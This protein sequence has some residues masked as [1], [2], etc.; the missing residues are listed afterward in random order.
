VSSVFLAFLLPFL[1][2]GIW[3]SPMLRG[4]PAPWARWLPGYGGI[5]VVLDGALTPGF[6]EAGSV[7]LALGWIAAFLVLASTVLAPRVSRA[8]GWSA[9]SSVPHSRPA[10]SGVAHA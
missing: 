2:L 10:P 9:S 3:Q 1:D 6:D 4:E 5:R 7:A 8:R